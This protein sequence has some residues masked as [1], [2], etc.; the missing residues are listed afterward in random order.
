MPHGSLWNFLLTVIQSVLRT[1]TMTNPLLPVF[2]KKVI[3]FTATLPEQVVVHLGS[4]NK[5][6]KAEWK[7]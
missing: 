3:M 4:E 2:S 6:G 7:V 1:I 5:P